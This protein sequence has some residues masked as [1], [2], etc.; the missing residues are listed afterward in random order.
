MTGVQTCAL[1][2]SYQAV[3]AAGKADK[4]KVFGFDGADDAIRGIAE[5]KIAATVMQFPVLMAQM[6][7]EMAHQYINGERDFSSKTPVEVIL[8][9]P[10]NVNEFM[11]EN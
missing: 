3:L 8:V 11:P 7:A 6:S 9:T 4:I 2:I 5:G 1:P 10:K